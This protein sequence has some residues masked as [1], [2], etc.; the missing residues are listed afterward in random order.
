[1]Y[2]LE[3]SPA[4]RTMGFLPMF[5]LEQIGPPQGAF[6]VV[7][8]AAFAHLLILIADV[9]VSEADSAFI[10]HGNVRFLLRTFDH[11]W[12]DEYLQLRP[13]GQTGRV[14]VVSGVAVSGLDPRQ[15]EDGRLTGFSGRNAV[16]TVPKAGNDRF[17]VF[18]AHRTEAKRFQLAH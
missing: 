18:A 7:K 2:L 15:L 14:L 11:D 8:M 3:S 17:D 10:R 12:L 16:E 9:H 5:V 6:F 13:F 1:M 4:N